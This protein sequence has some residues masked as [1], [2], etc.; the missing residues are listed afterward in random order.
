MNGGAE[1]LYE[2]IIAHTFPTLGKE[3]GIQVQEAQRTPLK[4]NKNR[5]IPRHIIVKLANFRDK[6]KILAKDQ[7]KRFVTYKG[8]NVRLAADLSIETWQA[9]T[10]TGMIQSVC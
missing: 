1:G 2:Q 4:I 8:R 7:D 3:I 9:R 10:E 6:E 5:S